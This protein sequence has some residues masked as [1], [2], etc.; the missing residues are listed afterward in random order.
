MWKMQCGHANLL[1]SCPPL[2]NPMHCSP[3]GS[4]VHGI[5]HLSWISSASVR[6]IPFLSFLEPIFAWNVPLVSLVFLKRSL[7]F[8]ILLFPS[9]S[10][11]WSLAPTV[12]LVLAGDTGTWLTCWEFRPRA[13]TGSCLCDE[14]DQELQAPVVSQVRHSPA[15]WPPPDVGS[16]CCP[17]APLLHHLSWRRG[18]F[19]SF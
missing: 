4:Y 8:P 18:L 19:L 3:P 5:R 15:W 13:A 7:L 14:P 2:C 9:I 11:H 16:D 6:P 10:L 12:S 17:P 1:Q